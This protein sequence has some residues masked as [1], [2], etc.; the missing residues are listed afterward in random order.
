MYM[1]KF[2]TSVQS[3]F[4]V[5]VSIFLL[6]SNQQFFSYVMH[7]YFKASSD[8]WTNQESRKSKRDSKKLSKVASHD[9]EEDR[10]TL[11]SDFNEITH[12]LIKYSMV[13]IHKQDNKNM[14][15]LTLRS[16]I[17][18]AHLGEIRTF[19]KPSFTFVFSF[20]S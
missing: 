17:G 15:R 6:V 2:H 11:F 5:V 13:T 9:A 8:P 19:L 12:L 14:V 4:V 10:W 20:R 18:L 7:L 3:F 1:L 16:V